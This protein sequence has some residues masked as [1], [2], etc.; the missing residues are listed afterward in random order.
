MS[1]LNLQEYQS[2]M[3]R[4]LVKA[5]NEADFY[6]LCQQAP[7]QA[8]REIFGCDLPEGRTLRFVEVAQGEW[9]VELPPW[10]PPA[11]GQELADSELDAVQ[12]GFGWSDI[13]SGF[14]DLG[15]DISSG[16]STANDYMSSHTYGIVNWN[17]I[18]TNL[19]AI[20]AGNLTGN[21]L[22]A[23]GMEGSVAGPIGVGVVVAGFVGYGIYEAAT[24]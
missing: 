17:F 4:L 22:V 8:Y 10:S 23:L 6:R 7:V 1:R 5:R 2:G 15:H 21:A 9:V 12:G 16:L 18:G 14:S 24:H 11:A 13:T 20:A 19:G 3:A